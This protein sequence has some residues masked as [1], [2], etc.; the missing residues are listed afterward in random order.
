M[1]QAYRSSVL[2]F[3]SSPKEAGDDSYEYFED[4]LLLV[5]NGKVVQL[6]DAETLLADMPEALEITHYPNAIITPG[7]VDAHVHYPQT[8]MIAAYGE[9]LLQ[10]LDTYTFPTEIKFADKQY[11]RTIA[12]KFLDEL[13]RAGTTTALVFGT[14]HKQSVEAFFEASAERNLRMICG[15]VLMDRNA[16]DELT[17]TAE[18]GY[19]DSKDLI[20]KWHNNGRQRYAVTPRFSPTSTRE[21]LQ[22]AGQLLQEFTDVYLHTHLSENKNEI[23]WV[24]DLF[25]ECK[26]YL[27]T[28][29]HA[30]LLG[31]RSV[32]AHCIHL[33]DDEWQRMSETQSNIAFCPTSNLFLGADYSTLSALTSITSKSV[34]VP[35]WVQVLAFLFCKHSTKLTKLCKCAA[36]SSLRLRAFIWQLWAVRKHWIWKA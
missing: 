5:D 2:H 20:Q 7:F 19:Q 27:D 17:D 12:D 16:P 25:P 26:N 30:G 22:K 1:L 34:W 11:A 8:E 4:G 35:M 9:Q 31:R 21:Q 24:K 13:V 28:Y 29:D 3:L 32:F 10:W 33:D 14:V 15:K 36:T 6:G 23:E 18:A